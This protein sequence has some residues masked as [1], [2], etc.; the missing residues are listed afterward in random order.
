V[1]DAA[2]RRVGVDGYAVLTG[3]KAAFGAAPRWTL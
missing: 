2:V 3:I 1:I